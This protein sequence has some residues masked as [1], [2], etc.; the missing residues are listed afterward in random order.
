MRGRPP[1]EELRAQQEVL[2]ETNADLGRQEAIQIAGGLRS[3]LHGW[4]RVL[5]RPEPGLALVDPGA[6]D[7]EVRGSTLGGA[8]LHRVATLLALITR[9]FEPPPGT[10]F[11]DGSANPTMLE[12][13]AAALVMS[14]G[15]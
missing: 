1:G 11:I 10:I 4:A 9:T 2:T 3:A 15:L 5:S 14:A 6:V 12:A 13:P 8:P 7:H